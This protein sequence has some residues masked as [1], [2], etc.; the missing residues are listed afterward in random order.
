MKAKIELVYSDF[1]ATVQHFF[2]VSN[3]I[4]SFLCVNKF[5]NSKLVEF[6]V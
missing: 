2:R 1:E 3:I 5:P 4:M 6:I